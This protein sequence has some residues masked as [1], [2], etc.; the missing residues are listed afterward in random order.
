MK[1][2]SSKMHDFAMCYRM[3]FCASNRKQSVFSIIG[4]TT[5]VVSPFVMI[6]LL[7]G[8]ISLV[9]SAALLV[10]ALPLILGIVLPILLLHNIAKYSR[11]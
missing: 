1:Y 9:L 5:L 11:E 10:S 3:P 4:D 6:T 2:A 8:I 7:I